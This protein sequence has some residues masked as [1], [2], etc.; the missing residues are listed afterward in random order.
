V[1]AVPLDVI[2][3]GIGFADQLVGLGAVIGVEA[4][5]DA[6]AEIDL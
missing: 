5:P 6:G 1:L 2:H 4:N 3:R